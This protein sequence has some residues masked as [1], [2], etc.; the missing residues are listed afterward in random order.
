MHETIRVPHAGACPIV[1]TLFYDRDWQG[2]ELQL[3]KNDHCLVLF[4]QL[5]LFPQVFGQVK[6]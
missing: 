1:F 2:R 3:M 5:G 6:N 4:N